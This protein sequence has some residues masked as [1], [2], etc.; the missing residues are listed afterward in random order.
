MKQFLRSRT[1]SN[2]K[3][4]AV[5]SVLLPSAVPNA[6]PL[7]RPMNGASL[8]WKRQTLHLISGI[9]RYGVYL[10]VERYIF[11]G[12]AGPY[13]QRENSLTKISQSS[14]VTA[15]ILYAWRWFEN[16]SAKSRP[17]LW[18]TKV[19]IGPR[20]GHRK[21]QKNRAYL[22]ENCQNQGW[23]WR[24]LVLKKILETILPQYWE[25]KWSCSTK[26]IN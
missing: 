15:T 12:K 8:Q 23:K 18:P 19:V 14:T 17:S 6:G 22:G 13:N 9:T 24:R 5:T 10:I 11:V 21:K 3:S 26:V 25:E 7:P 20:K 16:I 4:I 2:P 1:D